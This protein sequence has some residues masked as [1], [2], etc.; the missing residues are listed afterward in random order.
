[1][2]YHRTRDLLHVKQLLGHKAVKNTEIYTHLLSFRSDD[3]HVA[4]A[5]DLNEEAKLIEASFEYVRYS[6]V[7]KVSIYRRRR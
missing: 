4:F 6:D 7:D 2:E 1:M 3:H 5:K